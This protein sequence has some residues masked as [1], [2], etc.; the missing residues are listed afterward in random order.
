M[1][2]EEHIITLFPGVEELEIYATCKDQVI[3]TIQDLFVCQ[4]LQG[5]WQNWSLLRGI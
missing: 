4:E 5:V 1:E 2:I 3:K